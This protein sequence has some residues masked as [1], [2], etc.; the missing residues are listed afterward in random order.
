[1]TVMMIQ[2]LASH[3]IRIIRVAGCPISMLGTG[4]SCPMYHPPT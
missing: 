3:I 4:T 1:M 2:D